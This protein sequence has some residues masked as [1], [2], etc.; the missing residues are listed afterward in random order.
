MCGSSFFFLMI[1]RPRR[2]TLFPYTRLF[3]SKPGPWGRGGRTRRFYRK[4]FLAVKPAR[5]FLP[6]HRVLSYREDGTGCHP[7]RLPDGTA[8]SVSTMRNGRCA[9]SALRLVDRAPRWRA[10]HVPLSLSDLQ[11]PISEFPMGP[12]LS[13]PSRGSEGAYAHSGTL[14][15]G[16]LRRTNQRR[17]NRA[18]HLCGRLPDPER[19]AG[20][21]GRDLLPE[22]LCFRTAA[23]D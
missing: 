15:A 18:Q 12:P 21:H 3:R 22:A 9:P 5:K 19:C 8:P 13:P 23:P 1:R 7:L 2:S 14:R 6:H 16:L 17:W 4:A 11:P 20:P 10:P